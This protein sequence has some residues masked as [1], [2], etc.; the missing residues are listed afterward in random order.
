MSLFSPLN[1]LVLVVGFELLQRMFVVL[2]V[3]G[4]VKGVGA[5]S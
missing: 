1:W 2:K 5:G 4:D 3:K